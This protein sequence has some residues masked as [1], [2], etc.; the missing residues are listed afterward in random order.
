MNCKLYRAFNYKALLRSYGFDPSG[1]ESSY[2]KEMLQE[3]F[4]EKIGFHNR[5]RENE[6]ALVYD[7]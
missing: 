3:E 7:T 6:S 1:K 4:G 5:Y 2:I